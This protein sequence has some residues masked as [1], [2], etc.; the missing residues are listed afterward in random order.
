V[1]LLLLLVVVFGGGGCVC[2]GVQ[3]AGKDARACAAVLRAGPALV[4][5]SDGGWVAAPRSAWGEHYA[6]HP[7]DPSQTEA[8]FPP[9]CLYLVLMVYSL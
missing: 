3:R 4:L 9:S 6:T 8:P 7:R 1:S 2:G 5:D